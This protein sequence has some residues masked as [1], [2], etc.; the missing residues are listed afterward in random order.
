[1]VRIDHAAWGTCNA[2]L[3]VGTGQFIE[4]LDAAESS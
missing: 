1:V 2:V 4:L 3:A